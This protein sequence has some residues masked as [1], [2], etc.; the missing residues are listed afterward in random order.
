MFRGHLQVTGHMVCT[1]LLEIGGGVRQEE[2]I[3]DARS[4]E[5]PFHP[6]YGP[7]APEQVDLPRMGE[8]EVRAPG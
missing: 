4:E 8:P 2:I 5:N 1:D 7:E 6:G 3:P